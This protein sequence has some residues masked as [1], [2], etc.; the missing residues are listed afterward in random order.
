MLTDTK[1]WARE[2]FARKEDVLPRLRALENAKADRADRQLQVMRIMSANTVC[3]GNLG[4]EDKD[5]TMK[6]WLQNSCSTIG[7]KYTASIWTTPGKKKR[8]VVTF[9]SSSQAKSVREAPKELQN[10]A[11]K[12]ILVRQNK[13]KE[14]RGLW[15][16]IVR[17]A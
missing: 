9:D 15:A 6:D 13:T 1:D 5:K 11:G 14:Q 16:P 10:A 3:I 2:R 7:A 17:D 8:A 4:E 12:P